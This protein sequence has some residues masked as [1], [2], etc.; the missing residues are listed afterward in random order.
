[1]SA[2]AS[3]PL[4]SG[5]GGLGGHVGEL[6]RDRLGL[7]IRA[8]AEARDGASRLRIF[9]REIVCL[10][11][12]DLLHDVLVE[13]PASFEHARTTRLLLQPLLGEGLFISEGELWRRQRRLMAPLFT[14]SQVAG[15]APAMHAAATRVA[16]ELTA[17]EPLEFDPALAMTR[18]AMAVAG[19]TLFGIDTFGLARHDD[20]GAALHDAL[21]WSGK[22][23]G[24]L[25][26]IAQLLA[27]SALRRLSLRGPG[28]LRPTAASL[29][30]RLR[31]PALLPGRESRRFREALKIIDST[32]GRVIADRRAELANKNTTP[33]DDL[34]HRL[35]IA[36]D[37]DDAMTDRQVR[38]EAVTLFV[39][40]HETTAIA[41]TWSLHLM[42]THPEIQAAALAEADALGAPPTAA[43]LPRLGLLTRIFKEAMRLYP[44]I[45]TFTRESITDVIIGPH[46][47]PRGTTLYISPYT[48][49]RDPDH[50]PDPG[51]F[52]PGRFDPAA[53]SRR[54][55]TAW[56]P[57]G[58]GPRTCIGLHFAL[59]EG[60][61]VLATLLRRLRFTPTG[62][63]PT[64]VPHSTLRPAE[65]YRL[66]AHPR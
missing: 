39:A 31:G 20:L 43:D 12:P 33:R 65:N 32:I 36:R 37:G 54:P 23:A 21:Q 11:R 4:V 41:L 63:A 42:S 8:A 51:R 1:M 40:G 25:L 35:I 50:W 18:I 26:V 62:T 55:R 10:H 15:Y 61:V 56:L 49:H 13:Q 52:D 38:D 28:P 14:P 29:L 17:G 30:D 7:L 24:S 59:L 34:L 57:F 6:R 64:L 22:Q 9:G 2:L 27:V 58:A 16:D 47:I 66:L 46:P 5:A 19:A 60:P 3:I 48:L 44:P 45:Y 53:E